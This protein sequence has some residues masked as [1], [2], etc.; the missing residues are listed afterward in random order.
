VNAKAFEE[1]FTTIGTVEQNKSVLRKVELWD[2]IEQTSRY[3]Y[4]PEYND[5]IPL[6]VLDFEGANY[7]HQPEKRP[8][9]GAYVPRYQLLP[10]TAR[11]GM[12]FIIVEFT[13]NEDSIPD[14]EIEINIGKQIYS[15]YPINTTTVWFCDRYNRKPDPLYAGRTYIMTMQ[16]TVYRRSD[17][18]FRSVFT[19]A[20]ML[21]S[22]QYTKDGEV[23]PDATQG[24][25]YEE[26]TDGFYETERGKRWLTLAEN[27]ERPYSTIPVTATNSTKLLIP[28]YSGTAYV[29]E[30]VDISEE[31]YATGEPVCLVPASFARTNN[32]RIGDKI[33]LPLYYA[34]YRSSAGRAYG[35][36]EIWI[37]FN[38]LNTKGEAYPVFH[39][40]EYTVVGMYLSI[41]GN[42]SGYTMAKN[43]VII[44]AK[45]IKSSDKDNIIAYGPMM[46]YNTS[47]QIPNGTMDEY[48]EAFQKLGID[49]LRISLYD[50][51]Y[52]ELKAGLDH[53]KNMSLILFASGIIA[54][55]LI[56]VF[57]CN[58]FIT[59]QKKRTAIERSLGMSKWKCTYSMISGILLLVL[60]GSLIGSV[61]GFLLTNVAANV[62]SGRPSYDTT[63]TMGSSSNMI[64]EEAGIVYVNPVFALSAITCL[65]IIVVAFLISLLVIRSNLQCEP[66]EL[67]SEKME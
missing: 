57:F 12:D 59:K 32:L 8:F 7:I 45:S 14:H 4:V 21:G 18:S 34:N 42:S 52:T 27:I 39:E 56:L 60:V 24:L 49:E 43:E 35:Q 22:L 48:M 9:Y 41:G 62:L 26:V 47:F 25:L 36:N 58:L 61:T 67:L 64:G 38:T 1:V 54:T 19:P 6:S 65:I 23:Q 63:Y 13:V 2:A 5:P 15:R 46:G 16:N 3:Y 28:F 20:E 30:G 50:K 10:P 11:W 44:P 31:Q 29:L 37:G 51:G 40:E 66:L 17:S 55:M 33:T 53:I